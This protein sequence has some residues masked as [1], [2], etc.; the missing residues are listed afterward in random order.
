[1]HQQPQDVATMVFD[2]GSI[3]WLVTPD[4]VTDATSSFGEVVINP[5][6]GH[7]RHEHPD[8]DEVLYVIE[9]TGRRRSATGPSSTSPQAT[10]SG[11]PRAPCTPP[12][13]PAGSRCV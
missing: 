4:T 1:M 13:T 10:P 9:G 3:K 6:K 8:A 11:S 12:T 7:E 5:E 2:W